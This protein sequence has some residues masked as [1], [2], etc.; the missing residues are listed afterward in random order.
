MRCETVDFR[1]VISHCLQHRIKIQ[2]VTVEQ[3]Y[4]LAVSETIKC[5]SLFLI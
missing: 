4:A 5:A 3:S 2:I 1:D